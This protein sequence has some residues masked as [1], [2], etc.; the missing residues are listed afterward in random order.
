MSAPLSRLLASPSRL[1]ALERYR[2]LDTAAEPAFDNIVSL[3]RLLCET[4]VALVSLITADRQW[5]KARHGI[6][7]SETPVDQSVC[8]Y[9]IASG[10]IL[11]IPDLAR[12]PRTKENPMV[13][14]RPFM[15]FYAGAPLQTAEGEAL[16]SLCVIDY[17]PRHGGLTQLQTMSLELLANQ[18]VNILDLRVGSHS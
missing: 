2:V 4:P 10:R 18:V 3:A 17:A 16:G 1:A 15:R 14:D 5:F 9:T 7:I 12:D 8:A 11:V 13:A 6:D